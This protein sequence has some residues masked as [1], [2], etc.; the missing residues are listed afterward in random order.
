MRIGEGCFIPRTSNHSLSVEPTL[1]GCRRLGAVAAF[2]L[3][4]CVSAATGLYLKLQP[5]AHLHLVSERP[6]RVLGTQGVSLRIAQSICVVTVP[7]WLPWPPARF[8]AGLVAEALRGF[9]QFEGV[10]SLHAR[11]AG[12]GGPLHTTVAGSAQCQ[13]DA[14][15]TSSSYPGGRALLPH[16]PGWPGGSWGDLDS[17]VHV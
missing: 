15:H 6:P 5:A 7:R 3:L 8:R 12:E 11:L 16:R 17:S 10:A 1:R 9:P 14:T 4:G 13:P 2:V